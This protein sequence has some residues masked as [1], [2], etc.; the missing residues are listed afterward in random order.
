[1]SY[2]NIKAVLKS[3]QPMDCQQGKV[4]IGSLGDGGY[5]LPNDLEGI[6][7]VVSIGIGSEVSFDLAFA[8]RGARIVQF[9][10]TVEAPPQTHE[11]FEFHKLAWAAESSDSAKSLIDICSENE[12][13]NTNN[14]LLK[15]DVEGAEWPCLRNVNSDILKHFRII[16][17][18][19][20]GLNNL[21]ND[22]YLFGVWTVLN[23]LNLNHQV[24]HFHIN[25]CCGVS[26]LDG[27]L[28]PNTVE[29]TL[30]RRDRSIFSASLDQIPSSL[31]FPNMLGREDIR[32]TF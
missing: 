6:D 21:A 10:H 24:V 32:F 28:V 31:D 17:C 4:R 19:L 20:H 1:M 2:E 12:I 22:G 29:L 14:A 27:V 9:D 11:N 15:F 25:N 8:Q 5:V 13:L 26:F 16:T 23:K 7:Q 18:E 30:L 3:M